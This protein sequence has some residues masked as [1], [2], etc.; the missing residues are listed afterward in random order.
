MVGSEQHSGFR[1]AHV[2]Y[3]PYDLPRLRR[4]KLLSAK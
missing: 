1:Q 2:V 4:T 3:T